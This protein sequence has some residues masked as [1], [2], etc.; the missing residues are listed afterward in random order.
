MSLESS[1]QLG[2]KPRMWLN[3][4]KVAIIQKDA[5]AISTLL[6]ETPPFEN[7]DEMQE[8]L[9]LMRESLELLYTLQDE[10]K[11]S[12]KQIRKNLDFLQSSLADSKPRLNIKS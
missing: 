11:N 2:K 10:T 12:M 7:I 3:K 8:A 4:L 6:D 1:M 5:D 9:Y